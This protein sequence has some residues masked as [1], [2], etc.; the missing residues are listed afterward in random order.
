MA[1]SISTVEIRVY[2]GGDQDAVHRIAA[3]TAFFGQ[4]IENHIDDRRL[5]IDLFYRYYTEYEGETCWVACAEEDVIGFLTGC[6]NTRRKYGLMQRRIVPA[7]LRNWVS[8]GYKVGRKTV[9]HALRLMWSALSGKVPHVDIDAYPAHLHINIKEGWRGHRI[10]TRLMKT[11]FQQLRDLNTAGVHLFTTERN[12][13]ACRLYER[14]G[15]KILDSRITQLWEPF[16][17][18]SIENRVYGLQLN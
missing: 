3:D 6:A 2:Q 8:G 14:L 9:R 5:F 15:M 12:L 16:L 10:G 13:A 17:G 18:E 7:V 1:V 4:P 11:Y